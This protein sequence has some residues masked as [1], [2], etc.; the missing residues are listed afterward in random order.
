MF[1]YILAGFTGSFFSYFCVFWSGIELHAFARGTTSDKVISVINN[2]HYEIEREF[3]Q[4][5]KQINRNNDAIEEK[6]D[7]ILQKI[8]VPNHN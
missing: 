4:L 1:E 8:Y 3:K 5:V 6:F 2:N 7:R